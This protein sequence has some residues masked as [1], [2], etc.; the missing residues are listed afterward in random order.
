M[1]V[2]LFSLH[3]G[4]V[5]DSSSFIRYRC[6]CKFACPI[7][8]W[9]PILR[10]WVFSFI[11]S[12]YHSSTCGVVHF[13][14]LQSVCWLQVFWCF[15][16]HHSLI[17]FFMKLFCIGTDGFGP[18][19]TWLAPLLANLSAIS[20]PICPSCPGIQLRVIWLFLGSSLTILVPG[21]GGVKTTQRFL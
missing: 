16:L 5:E 20:L 10:S 9:V 15:Y 6:L 17:L 11:R 8:N 3:F 13:V 14:C 19:I 18:I 21:V 4:Q 7:S 2:S 1:V 12:L